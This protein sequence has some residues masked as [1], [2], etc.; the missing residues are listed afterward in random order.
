MGPGCCSASRSNWVGNLVE[1]RRLILKVRDRIGRCGGLIGVS[2]FF[3]HKKEVA[4]LGGPSG[5]V[6]SIFIA[7]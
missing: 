7:R 2:H 4:S 5:A 3:L 1:R 6:P